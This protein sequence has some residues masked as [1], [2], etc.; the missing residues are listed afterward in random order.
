MIA[1]SSSTTNS[2]KTISSS[3]TYFTS[4]TSTSSSNSSFESSST[5]RSLPCPQQTQLSLQKKQVKKFKASPSNK[6]TP[7]QSLPKDLNNNS[8][9]FKDMNNVGGE[10]N[11]TN[12]NQSNIK[13]KI[14][15]F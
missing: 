12:N 2:A 1:S 4:T 3:L 7:T 10:T 11:N 6:K 14:V 15:D 8:G 5:S 9:C 13:N